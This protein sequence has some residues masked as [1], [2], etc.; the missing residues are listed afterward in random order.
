MTDMRILSLVI[1]FTAILLCSTA[2]MANGSEIKINYADTYPPLS[3]G[4]Q[5]NVQ[6]V[7]PALMEG[8]IERGMSYRIIH[9][10]K[11]WKRAQQEVWSGRA[12]ALITSITP[13]RLKHSYRSDKP[14]FRLSFRPFTKVN[15]PATMALENNPPISKLKNFRFCDVHGN[16]WGKQFYEKHN[17]KFHITRSFETCL[18]LLTV[19]RT[20]IVIHSDHILSAI[21]QENNWGGLIK[22]HPQVMPESPE[23]HFLLSKKSKLSRNFLAQFD[24][25]L[26][27]MRNDGSYARLMRSL[28]E[29][30]SIPVTLNSW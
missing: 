20:D 26:M 30:F 7:L 15:S 3:Y 22:A 23:F 14:V 5:A 17:I 11:A 18:R 13:E 28:N 25:T 4:E 10:G 19:G 24:L 2:T 9:R 8:I 12:D 1:S 16:L 29:K 21:I 27:R 6:G